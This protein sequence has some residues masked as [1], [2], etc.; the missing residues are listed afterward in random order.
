MDIAVVGNVIAIV[1]QGRRIEGQ[2]PEGGD[3]QILQIIELLGQPAKVAN[4]IAIAVVKGADVE[5]VDDRILVPQGIIVK[6]EDVFVM[7][8]AA[9]LVRDEEHTRGCIRFPRM[10]IAGGGRRPCLH[11]RLSGQNIKHR[12]Y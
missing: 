2:Q 11:G 5:F 6:R 1:A 7:A 9:L 3:A 10:P 8:H 4:A 12:Y